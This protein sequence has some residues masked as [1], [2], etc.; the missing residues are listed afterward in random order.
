MCPL[1]NPT[2]STSRRHFYDLYPLRSAFTADLL[3]NNNSDLT[4]TLSKDNSASV[5]AQYI[6]HVMKDQLYAVQLRPGMA[7]FAKIKNSQEGNGDQEVEDEAEE[8]VKG[9]SVRK[10]PFVWKRV[11]FCGLDAVEINP[12]AD[13]K[14]LSLGDVKFRVKVAALPFSSPSKRKQA[15]GC[16]EEEEGYYPVALK[17]YYSVTLKELALDKYMLSQQQSLQHAS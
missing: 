4:L 12:S 6:R 1:P 13:T 17:E 3:R 9:K 11:I 15:T 7:C 10:L 16:R 5:D 14:S 2:K 8:E